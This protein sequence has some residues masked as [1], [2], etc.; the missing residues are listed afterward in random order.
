MTRGRRFGVAICAFALWLDGVC[1]GAAMA[2]DPTRPMLDQALDNAIT[3]KLTPSFALAVV[4]DGKIAYDS[5]RGMA[6]L[7][8]RQTATAE[9]RYAIGSVGTLFIMVGIMQLSAQ[10]RLRLNDSVRRYLP[11]ESPMDVTLHEMLVSREDG[12]YSA[13]GSV[14]ERV[15]GEPLLT[16]LT[17]RVFRP[18]GM[19]QT[20][21]GE[22][23]SWLPLAARYYEWRDDFGVADAESDAWSQKCC[24]AVS[25][26]TDLARFDIALFNGTLLSQASL[27]GIEPFFQSMQKGGTLMI[28]RQGSAAGFDAE[29]ILLPKQRFAIVILAN[30]A[31]FA[32]TP[33]LDRVLGLYYPALANASGNVDPNPAVTSRLQ[34]YLT[35]QSPASV[36]T[37]SFLSSSESAGS[38]EYRYLVDVGGATR[39]A[40]FV[41][42][43]KDNI[44]G[45]WLH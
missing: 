35:Q 24:S 5:T 43:P 31:G 9:T 38:T 10:G 30:C 16:Y 14:I 7:E 41:L 32:A 27:R 25:T 28:G 18:A 8:R 44:N 42:D 37:M 13:L 17:D 1:G 23:P 33:V 3:W 21:L 26:A 34:N 4:Q 15:T 39:S 20:W 2:S 19:T 22:P 36:G 6:D 12:A 40:F 29:N 45:F 11:E